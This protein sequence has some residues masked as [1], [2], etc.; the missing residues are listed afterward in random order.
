MRITSYSFALLSSIEPIRCV[1]SSGR[2]DFI[3]AYVHS[4]WLCVLVVLSWSSWLHELVSLLLGQGLL[5]GWELVGGESLLFIDLNIGFELHVLL[6]VLVESGSGVALLAP[7]V[8]GKFVVSL[9]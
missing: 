9:L 6:V 7:V 3:S 4:L 5:D 2:R 8:K 1:N